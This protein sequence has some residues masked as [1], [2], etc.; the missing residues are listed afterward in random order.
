MEERRKYAKIA[1]LEQRGGGNNAARTPMNNPFAAR[2][3]KAV[4]STSRQEIVLLPTS[5]GTVPIDILERTLNVVT[6]SVPIANY[7]NN[8]HAEDENLRLGNF[9]DGI[10]TI[11]AVMLIKW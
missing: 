2:V 6:L 7:D 11:A 10:E 1:R 9:F 4:Q 8:Q 3:S 5:G